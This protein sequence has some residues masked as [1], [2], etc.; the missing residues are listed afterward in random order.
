MRRVLDAHVHVWDPSVLRY[1]WLSGGFDRSFLPGDIPRRPDDQTSMIFVEAGAT[2]GL[3]EANWVA[4]LD[5]P[6]RVG[7]VAQVDVS[8]GDAIASRLEQVAAV[9]GVVGV[10]WNLQDDPVE[11]FESAELV[12]GLRLVA[13]R[14]LAFDACVRHHQLPALRGLIARVPELPVVLDHLGKPDASHAPQQEWLS[15]LRSLAPLPNVSIKLSG[16]PPEADPGREIAPQAGPLLAAALDVFGSSRCMVG[17]DWPVSAATAHR[18]GPAEWF[19]VVFASLGASGDE[20]DRLSRRTAS[21]F[22]GV[23]LDAS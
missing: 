15:D 20:L 14:G 7:I 18:V 10:R 19:D 21:E 8:Q 16:V 13:A 1:D 6:E 12:A 22:Y 11:N 2:D 3:A 5:W 9:D 23:A 17:S 4:G